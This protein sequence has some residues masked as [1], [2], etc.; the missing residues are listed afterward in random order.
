MTSPLS[1]SLTQI[2]LLGVG[3]LSLLFACAWVAEKGWLP[4]K[5]VRHPLVY[6]LALGMYASAWAFYSV[7]GMA[8]R[9]GYAFLTYYLGIS[10]AFVLAPLLF[11]PLL[12]LARTHQLSS[13]ADLFAFRY[14]SRLI[15]MLVAGGLLLGSMPLF[16]MQIQAIA[17][18]IFLLTNESAPHHLAFV[19]CAVITLFAILF[20]A[21]HIS[22]RERHES[23]LVA[24][25]FESLIK[26]IG[27]LSL[28]AF[29]LWGVF[30]GVDGLEQWLI[31]EGDQL[32]AAIT[33]L[34]DHQWRT[35]LLLFFA[36]A[37][38]MPHIFHIIFAEN[39]SEPALL[40]ASWAMPLFLLLLAL[41]VPVIYWAYLA[42]GS[43]L[44]AEYATLSFGNSW[45]L[46]SFIVGLAAASGSMIVM[47]LA[48]APMLLNHLVL[49]LYRPP[50][51]LD[52]YYWL[53]WMR[54]LIIALLIF[55]AYLVYLVL[56]EQHDLA[57][58]GLS[59]FIAT[60]QF[61]PGVLALL[62]WPSANRIGLS[63]GLIG[64][65]LVW[66]IGLGFPL[67]LGI[68][69]LSWGKWVLPL[70][71]F[72]DWYPV[73][74]L[75]IT[76]NLG[77][78]ILFSLLTPT[79]E[80]EK[81]A[82]A[83]C[84]QNLWLRPQRRVVA[85]HKCEDF[86]QLL[87]PPLGQE[88]AQREVEQALKELRLSPTDRRPLAMQRLRDQLQANLSGLMGSSVAQVL[89]DRYLP[90]QVESNTSQRDLP[91]IEEQLELYQNHLTG[92][93]KELDAL[94]RHHRQTLHSLPIGV[95]TLDQNHHIQFWNA[96]LAQLTQLPAEDTLG[97][98]LEALPAPW[99]Q[100]L[101]N[102]YHQSAESINGMAIQQGG[103]PLWISLQKASVSREQQLST[104][105]VLLIE[106]QTE[107]KRLEDH[108]LHRERLASIGQLA[109][110]VAHEI[111]NPVTGISSLVQNLHYDAEDPTLVRET[112]DAIHQLTQ[113]INHI[114]Q[115]LVSFAHAGKSRPEL[116]FE[117][118]SLHATLA[119]AIALLRLGSHEQERDYRN[120]CAQDLFIL[121]DP[122]RL[123]Q[124]LIN[125]LSNAR[126]A[127][128]RGGRILC[129][130]HA[131]ETHI[132]IEIHDDGSGITPEQQEQLFTPFYTTKAAGQGTGLGLALVYS[133][134]AEHGGQIS[135]E[136]PS[137]L[138]AT[139]S[140]FRCQFPRWPVTALQQPEDTQA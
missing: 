36:T 136:S 21:R 17:D 19:F 138:T 78:F 82:A 35:L 38:A 90:W 79:S 40:Q 114:V 9:Y 137:A 83:L 46:V 88:T 91:Y 60:L 14:R 103:Q 111:G 68:D 25:A 48:L 30:G 4:K 42:H 135:C 96:A 89:T 118:T 74:L 39:P 134:V 100:P 32:Q 77:C 12:R 76:V 117:Q 1:F 10:A 7:F 110:G 123:Q 18:V 34:A 54:R 122:Q 20:G 3:Y 59:A 124:V 93:A 26:L 24:I 121:G 57:T 8:E 113:R 52:I 95:C 115:T 64:G 87:T 99:G 73:A 119:A 80:E 109:A 65:F 56:H 102:F 5:L 13:L 45:S 129:T 127:T 133:I 2:F 31:A 85:A 81:Q 105:A 130:S 101:H 27:F 53:I 15:G 112:A 98:S 63:L 128:Q 33:P 23:L 126:D 62:Y 71:G 72:D 49:P 86:V 139:G 131:N 43:D 97:L 66:G 16:A 58:L 44:A 140:C 6:I 41:P 84:S 132:W 75:S 116:A 61:L 51:R 11:L 47:T 70:Q 125:L 120:L 37:V 50:A 92:M 69:Q 28:G 104:G 29:A 22:L 108:L 67:M 94:R 107:R 55:A 106:D